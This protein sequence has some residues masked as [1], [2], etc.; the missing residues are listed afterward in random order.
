LQQASRLI[1]IIFSFF[2][3]FTF[4][5]FYILKVFLT[6]VKPPVGTKMTEVSKFV[7]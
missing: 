2:N 5:F 3:C 7:W 1:V 6:T 4:I